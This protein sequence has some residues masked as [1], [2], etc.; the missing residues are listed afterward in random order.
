MNCSECGNRN[1]A[2]FQRQN[3]KYT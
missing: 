1:C 3:R 2:I